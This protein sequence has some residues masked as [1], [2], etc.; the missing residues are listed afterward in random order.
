[1]A[2]PN[3]VGS[4]SKDGEIV[5]QEACAV[6]PVGTYEAYVKE[7][8]ASFAEEVS[9]AKAEGFELNTP[10]NLDTVIPARNQFETMKAYKGFECRRLR[11]MSD[12]LQVVAYI[13]K[14]SATESKPLPVIIFN[15]GGRG[16]FG[17]IGTSPI[18]SP[19]DRFGFHKF[20]SSGFVVIASQYRG[21]DGGEGKEDFGG[22]DV[23][24]VLNLIPLVRGLSYADA[25]NIF[26]MGVS[27]GGMM[28]YLALKGGI[29][30]RAAA[31]IGGAADLLALMKQRPEMRTDLMDVV[32]GLTPRNDVPLRE[33]SVVYWPERITVPVLIMA[34]GSDWRVNPLTNALSL[35]TK[36]QALRARY[37]LVV[38]EDDDHGLTMNRAD[39]D[40]RIIRWFKQHMSK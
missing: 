31:T 40:A 14:P 6:K 18:W 10:S 9:E 28:T 17:Q 15:R 29:E 5:S 4:T 16:E 23:H 32:P 22:S 21:N 1:V 34:G 37:E 39:S 3:A 12:G 13:W 35:A 25:K 33:R 27:R 24:D 7:F 30:V 19:W 38:Y 20:V 26:L 8:R 11:Y 36:L 2:G